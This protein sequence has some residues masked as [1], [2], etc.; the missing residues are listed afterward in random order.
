MTTSAPLTQTTP[1][2]PKGTSAQTWVLLAITFVVGA[3][4][5][6][7]AGTHTSLM[8]VLVPMLVTVAMLSPKSLLLMLT[9]W[10]AELGLTRRLIPGGTSATFSGDPLL[11]VGPAVIIFLFV[12]AANRGALQRRTPLAKW[13]LA[14]SGVCILEALN[15]SQGGLTV[16]LGGLLFVLVPMLVFWIGRQFLDARE[17][18]RIVRVVAWLGLFSAIYGLYQEFSH[19]PSWDQRWIQSSGYTSLNIGSDVTRAFGSA[20]SAQEYAA[21]L[22]LSL[23]AWLVLLK[24]AK[25]YMIIVNLA[26]IGTIGYALFYEAQRTALVLTVIGMA[27]V[28]SARFKVKPVGM[29]VTGVVAVAL[30]VTFAGRIDTSSSCA[31][32]DT[33]CQATARNG[34]LAHPL[35]SQSTLSGHLTETRKGI[36]FGISHPLGNGVGS[37]TLA[38]GRF[39]SARSARGTEFDPGNAGAGFGWVGLVMYPVILLLGLRTAYRIAIRRNDTLGL[40][41]L[42]AVSVDLFQWLNGDLYSVTWLVWLFLGWADARERDHLFNLEEEVVEAVPAPVVQHAAGRFAQLPEQRRRTTWA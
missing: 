16:G 7:A 19:F 15:P 28:I 9:I 42:G 21:F 13:V 29:L 22:G 33:K 31:T 6:S 1:E 35:G 4:V 3:V 32:G 25:R 38:A 18:I 10:M 14:F 12:V 11:I 24:G 41:A 34:V 26:A 17:A 39:N 2:P 27:I 23:V 40:F 8:L 30:L 20:S 36:D 37:I 5:V